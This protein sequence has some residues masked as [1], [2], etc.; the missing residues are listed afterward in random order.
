MQNNN[1]DL[2]FSVSIDN[3]ELKKDADESKRIL[4][5]IGQTAE[6][7][8]ETI[9]ASMKK[10]GAAVAGVFAISQLKEFA[11][12]VANV[13][14]E[15]QQLE[16]AFETML[17]SKQQA[18]A[19]MSQLIRTAA[20]T[21]FNMSDIANG[22]KQLLAY[23]TA[24]EEVN[25]TLTRLG[26]IASGL[27]IPLNDLVYL[28]GTTM[29]QG[30]MFTQ[31]LRQFMGKGI[32]LAEELAKQFGVTKDKVGE[33]VTAG[34][35]GAK[36]F[37]QAIW[38]LTNEGSKF[39][40]LMAKQSQSIKGALSNLEDEIEQMYNEIGKKTDGVIMDSIGIASKIVKNWEA[41]GKVVLTVAATYGTYKA[42]VMAVYAVHKLAAIWKQVEAFMELTKSVNVAT[43]AMRAFNVATRANIVGAVLSLIAAATTAFL[44]FRDSADEA[45]EELQGM[46]KVSK[47]ADEEFAQQASRID[48]LTSVIDSNTASLDEKK[49]AI[50]KL[51]EII[52]SYTAELDSEGKV[53]RS[54]TQAIKDYLAE[55]EKQIRLKAAQ[56][57]LEDLYRRKRLKEK[58]EKKEQ[59][60]LDEQNALWLSAVS[61]YE[62]N[63]LEA[64]PHRRLLS[65]LERDMN[66][67]GAESAARK[68]KDK[69]QE[70]RKEISDLNQSIKEVEDEIVKSGASIFGGGSVDPEKPPKTPNASAEL[71]DEVAERRRKIQEYGRALSEEERRNALDIRQA[72]ID[73]TQE[74][75]D[76]ELAMIKLNYDRLADA[77]VNREKE[78]LKALANNKLDEWMSKNPKAT[79]AQ[80]ID[81]LNSLNLTR[82]D[83]TPTQ[84][85][86]L[87][88]YDTVNAQIYLKQQQELY[89][90][91][92]EGYQDF[93]ARRQAIKEK[94]A[95][96][97]LALESITEKDASK[98]IV[99]YDKMTAEQRAEAWNEYSVKV[100]AAIT[101]LSTKEKEEIKSVNDEQVEAMQQSSTLL[102]DLFSDA[103]DKSDKQIRRLI[104]DTQKLVDY[105][106]DTS[107]EEITPQFGFTAEQ[108][109]TIKNSPEQLNEI[110]EK[111]KELKDVARKNNPFRALVT[112]IKELFSKKK[113]GEEKE[114]TEARLKKLG[115]SASECADMVGDLAGQLSEMFAAAGND[116]LA[117]AME[118][119]QGVMTSVSN[120]GQGFAQ[121]GVVGGIAAVAGEAIGWVTKA[122]AAS[123]RHAAALKEIMNEVTAQQR[124]YNIALLEESLAM[125]KAATVFGTIDY[126]KASNAVYVMRQAW[127]DLR[128]EIEGTAEQQAKF[129]K[130]LNVKTLGGVLDVANAAYSAAK[131]AY[132]GLADIDIKTGHKKTGLFGWGKGKDIYS[133]ILDV[134]PELIDGQGKFNVELAKTI[135][136]TRTFSN[137]GKEALQYMINLAEKAEEAS[138]NVRTYLTGIFGE[139]GNTMSDALVD[140]FRNGTDAAKTF[141]D[142][143]T[144]MLENLGS[145]MIFSTMFGEIIQ[146]AN[147][148]MLATMTNITMTEEQKFNEYISILD[149]MTSGILGQQDNYNALM[150]RYRQLAADKGISLWQASD[151]S[152]RSASEKGIA[153]ASQDS[154]DEL[155]G[156]MTAVQGHT[157]SISENTKQLVS[158]TQ[159][160]LRSVM[161][162]ERNTDRLASVESD[163]S[164]IKHS[165]SDISLKGVRIQS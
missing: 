141:F 134:Y 137:E 114:S 20:T 39:G 3:I 140:A 147:D 88:A 139:L 93:N 7:E 42:A 142:S 77:N 98:L 126:S 156:R 6:K 71:A 162:I 12:H 57:E 13:R 61:G 38:S 62:G 23:G 102:V 40:G 49:K 122:F 131:L 60:E 46:A 129:A 84:R 109:K 92:L 47:Q 120:I 51:R 117:G 99:G 151:E 44:L 165:L 27:S 43:A 135:V 11:S 56:D 16:I 138:E 8:G 80:Q 24:S 163:I 89:N 32:P 125:E 161:A 64:G 37:Q 159:E 52:P 127:A 30:R 14:G 79:Q 48:A 22:A 153:T 5:G 68:I 1:G 121:G 155:N 164:S 86:Q 128:I 65:S 31:D 107:D 157:Y 26:D 116:S 136:E 146:D 105:L 17:G 97:R 21:P 34:K 124:S 150:E 103:A 94:Y 85:S 87:E 96:D 10:I 45:A 74:G 81:F 9:D 111:L 91:L 66:K 90:R 112:D 108:L 101:E 130:T 119:I 76:K 25:E 115:E 82:A 69:L 33:L 145:Q 123:A 18:D 29:T 4:H 15:F 148:A 133:S 100:Q 132:A 73:A 41:I 2:Q 154:I 35:V 160:I 83:L 152:N 144:D 67:A 158:N 59:A 55:L 110:I 78:M 113:E 28:Y 50:N 19:L 63:M 54:N 104:E 72:S 75:F 95:K 106:R 36:E 118:D 70:T 53:I 58:Q 149:T 143:V